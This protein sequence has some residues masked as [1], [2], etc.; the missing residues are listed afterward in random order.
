MKAKSNGLT[1][2]SWVSEGGDKENG[3]EEMFEEIPTENFSR[4]DGN[5]TQKF[6]KTK[7]EFLEMI[8]IDKYLARLT[9]GVE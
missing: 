4:I 9:Y 2:C 3:T 8:E 6:G 5:L 7:R 1:S